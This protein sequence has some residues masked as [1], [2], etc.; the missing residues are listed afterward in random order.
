MAIALADAIAPFSIAEPQKSIYYW[1]DFYGISR[2]E[3]Y[4]TLRCESGFNPSAIGAA[5][6]I[7][8]AQI[9]LKYHPGVTRE[10]ALDP[11][12]AIRWTALQFAN[13]N[14]QWWTCHSRLFS[15]NI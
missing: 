1:A 14:E 15:E 5:G 4:E 11:D 12:F 9:Y 10:D 8:I 3:L 2:V 6:E 7:G 13:G